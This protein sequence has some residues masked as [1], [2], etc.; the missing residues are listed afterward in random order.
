MIH[1]ICD[2][3]KERPA[4]GLRQ[5]AGVLDLAENRGYLASAIFVAVN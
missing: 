3:G 4:T 1:Q 2:R 5:M